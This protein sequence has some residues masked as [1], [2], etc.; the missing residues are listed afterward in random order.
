MRQ[1]ITL[2]ILLAIAGC[3]WFGAK[4]DPTED[5]SA[6]RLYDYAKGKLDQ[7]NYKD[8][9]EYY[10]KLEA[11]YPFGIY[12]Q[13][14]LLDV[15]YAYYKNGEPDSAIAACDRF[16]KL[17]P[18][19]PNVDYAYYLKG[20]ANFNMGKTLIHIYLPIDISQRDPG[21][22]LQAFR[23]FSELVKRYPDS[24]YVEDA[25]LRML[26][27]RNMLARYEVNVAYYYM[28]RGVY[29]AAANR[30]R[31]VVENYPRTTAV[32]DALVVMCKAYKIMGLNEL[33]NDALRVLKLNYPD[34]PAIAEIDAIVVK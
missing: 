11:R 19:H 32:P 13:Q 17:Y 2:V 14:G 28:R 34:N 5:W 26:Y 16:I 29:L 18:Q 31:Y 21:S 24:I 33:S 1:V 10:E 15:A 22:A 25:K 23:D 4:K 27:L 8:A 6:E 12:G 3:A 20:L 9:I 30:G 7:G